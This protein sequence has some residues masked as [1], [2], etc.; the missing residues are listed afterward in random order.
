MAVRVAFERSP[1]IGVFCTLTNAYCLTARGTSETFARR[2]LRNPMLV[3]VHKRMLL[4]QSGGSNLA[5]FS[6]R[7]WG[8]NSRW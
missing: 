8:T 3:G 1:E 4:K 6:K 7:N 2:A 5:A